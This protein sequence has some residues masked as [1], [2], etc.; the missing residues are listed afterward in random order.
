VTVY[1]RKSARVSVVV[2]V[3]LSFGA[4]IVALGAVMATTTATSFA[5]DRK[6][7]SVGLESAA[8]RAGDWE[9]EGITGGQTVLDG[10][11]RQ[12]SIASLDP[13][14]CKSAFEGLESVADQGSIYLLTPDKRVV[15]S[16]L[17]RRRP[18]VDVPVGGWF[19]AVQKSGEFEYGGILVERVTGT[20]QAIIASPV[21][22]D[23]G[24]G[25]IVAALDTASVALEIPPNALPKTVLVELDKARQNVLVTS[26]GAPLK[27]G[28]L[29]KQS[30]MRRPLGKDH[31][32]RDPDGVVRIYEEVPVAGLDRVVY[33]GVAR[34]VALRAATTERTRNIALSAGILVLVGYLGYTVQR[35]IA[36]PIARLQSAIHEAGEDGTVQAPTGGPSEIAA[37][38][39]EFNATMA[40]RHDLEVDLAAS[41]VKAE[42]ASRMKSL[43]LA[44]VSH[45]IRT[46]MNGVLGMI[47][48]LRDEA[49]TPEQRDYLD[50]M[51]DSASGLMAVI[52]DLLD[53]SRIEAGMVE[54][55]IVSFEL[56]HC[57]RSA[58]S[59]WAPVAKAKDVEL[60]VSIDDDVPVFVSGDGARLRRVVSNLVDNAVKFTPAGNVAVRVERVAGGVRVTVSDT[61][62]GIGDRKTDE[63]F[64]AFVQGDPTTTRR[65]GGTGLGLAICKQL[66][67]LMRGHIDA[68]PRADG[69]GSV[70]SFELP[71]PAAE[72]PQAEVASPS[73]A[74][75]RLSGVVLIAE[76]NVVN[77]KVARASVEQLGFEVDIAANGREA[78]DMVAANSY[79]AILMDLQMPE[80]DGFEATAAIRREL[81][82]TVPVYALSA[83]VL[84]EDVA[85]CEEAGMNGHLGK[86]I[87]RAALRDALERAVTASAQ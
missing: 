65:F 38:A 34:S 33:A 17:E 15:C 32:Q 86:P 18:I 27:V 56:R 77:Q 24:T 70:F 55:D 59:P 1:R 31:V 78:V 9:V 69:P 80:M 47:G 75:A 35:Q 83:S 40:K 71:L 28:A 7:A 12:D 26:P 85:R 84:P 50:T 41:V 64:E 54:T 14:R 52:N 25:V 29:P 49:L 57:V 2:Y 5:R 3:L 51:N 20:P 43:F 19:E 44:N 23:H 11:A 82:S 53:F 87:D 76:D 10:L 74:P 4:C 67:T 22:T 16:L 66:V 6:Q 45:E 39:D 37:L 68:A 72:D 13:E 61:G 48:L 73:P 79:V 21:A 62:V 63:V 36:R 58:V 42:E 8:R 81:G 60:T 46:P 30:W